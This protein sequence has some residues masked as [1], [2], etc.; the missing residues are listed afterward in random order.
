MHGESIHNLTEIK[1]DS[2]LSQLEERYQSSQ[3]IHEKEEDENVGPLIT[4]KDKF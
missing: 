3:P 4:S 1:E 2:G